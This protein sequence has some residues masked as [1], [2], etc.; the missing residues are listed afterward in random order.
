MHSR[1]HAANTTVVGE[2]RRK[3]RSSWDV[4][5]FTVQTFFFFVF[6]VT[7]TEPYLTRLRIVK[8]ERFPI[9]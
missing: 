4:H 8:E 5:H 7:G 1:G 9:Y 6:I 2:E 3:K